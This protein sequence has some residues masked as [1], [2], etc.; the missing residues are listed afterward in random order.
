MIISVEIVYE[1][2][3]D[4]EVIGILQHELDFNTINLKQE[5][6][7]T[8]PNMDEGRAYGQFFYAWLMTKKGFE[9]ASCYEMS[10]I[11]TICFQHG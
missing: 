8:F 3:T 9:K 11:E 1:G 4:N 7:E 2:W 6:A 5:F 10:D